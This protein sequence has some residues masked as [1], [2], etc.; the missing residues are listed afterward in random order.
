MPHYDSLGL[1]GVGN[2][3]LEKSA[4]ARKGSGKPFPWPFKPHVA[5]YK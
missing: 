5:I 1:S 4:A 2:G 3:Y